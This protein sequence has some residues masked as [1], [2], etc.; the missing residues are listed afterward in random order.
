MTHQLK[1]TILIFIIV[2]ASSLFYT[3]AWGPMTHLFL[4]SL[5][6]NETATSSTLFYAG[7]N[8]PDILKKEWPEL[9]SLE[10]AKD[11]FWHA[12]NSTTDDLIEFAL[13]FG[14]HIASDEVG[15]HSKGFLNPPSADHE[16]EFNLDSMIYHERKG[17]KFDATT[18]SDLTEREIDLIIRAA[19]QHTL[20]L[21]ATHRNLRHG[22]IS[23]NFI[24]QARIQSAIKHFQLLTSAERSLIRIQPSSLY[25]FELQRNS[26]CNNV[27]NYQEVIANFNVSA[28]WA[29]STCILWRSTMWSLIKHGNLNEAAAIMHQA[30]N[31][32]FRSNN[33][34]SCVI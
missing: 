1:T 25:Q 6:D 28:D 9:H 21:P 32:M 30:V 29:A 11:L 12:Y 13:G 4:C 20:M 7:C 24:D 5:A 31:E 17:E 14:C 22:V 33:G 23:P 26:F 8:S 3:H 10:F 18:K 2:W 19:S 15:H 16:I 27:S 34:T